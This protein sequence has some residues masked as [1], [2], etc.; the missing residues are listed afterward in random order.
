MT[1]VYPARGR[2][3]VGKPG[4][5]REARFGGLRCAK[6]R[7][8]LKHWRM[9]IR[10][11]DGDLLNLSGSPDK[12]LICRLRVSAV[13]KWTKYSVVTDTGPFGFSHSLE[14]PH[15]HQFAL[16]LSVCSSLR[17]FYFRVRISRLGVLSS[18]FP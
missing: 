1:Q 14:F 11:D 2:H 9:D 15:P 7:L 12:Q 8:R 6:L 17:I 3:G 13:W 16:K 10:S 18:E 5:W 4:V